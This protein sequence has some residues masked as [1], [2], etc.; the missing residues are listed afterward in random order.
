MGA[1]LEVAAFELNMAKN[2]SSPNNRSVVMPKRM[3]MNN[4]NGMNTH[5]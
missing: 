1:F 5:T 2:A 3:I 4:Q